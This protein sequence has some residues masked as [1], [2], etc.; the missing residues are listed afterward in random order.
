MPTITDYSAVP[1]HENLMIP[2]DSR[3]R[4]PFDN[5]YVEEL[6]DRVRLND[7]AALESIHR[8]LYPLLLNYAWS[9]MNCSNAGDEII[10]E[11]FVELWQ[12]RNEITKERMKIALVKHIRVLAN[13][14]LNRLTIERD[15]AERETPMSNNLL[16]APWYSFNSF[17]FKKREIE[18]LRTY[19]ELD[20]VMITDILSC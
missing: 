19:L 7:L 5:K 16:I 17:D 11:S 20:C 4:I 10:T 8:T 9:I 12:K 1:D 2:F 6:W 14:C 3:F 13:N 15:A 18:Y